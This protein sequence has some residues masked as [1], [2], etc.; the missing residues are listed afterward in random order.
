MHKVLI[1][2]QLFAF[3]Y[4]I[5]DLETMCITTGYMSHYRYIVKRK[6]LTDSECATHRTFTKRLLFNH[7]SKHNNANKTKIIVEIVLFNHTVMDVVFDGGHYTILL[8]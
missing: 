4:I 5:H 1:V 6:R 2:L 7:S 3:D 8:R